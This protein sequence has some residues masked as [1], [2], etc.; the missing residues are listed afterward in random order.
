M[1]SNAKVKKDKRK[2]TICKEKKYS[3]YSITLAL[4]LIDKLYLQT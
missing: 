4:I 2:D 3:F 1:H